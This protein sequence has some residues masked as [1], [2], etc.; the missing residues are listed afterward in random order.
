MLRRIRR[1][2]LRRWLRRFMGPFVMGSPE[3]M[4]EWIE[5]VVRRKIP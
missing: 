2:L 3:E 1:W 4:K 5:E